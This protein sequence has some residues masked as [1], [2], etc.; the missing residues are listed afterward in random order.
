MVEKTD[1]IS[2]LED[3]IARDLK[4]TYELE[5]K[6]KVSGSFFSILFV[7]SLC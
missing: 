7:N 3:E 1:Q 5:E 6:L 4:R 2:K